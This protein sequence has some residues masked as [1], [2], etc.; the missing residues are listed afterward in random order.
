MSAK[1]KKESVAPPTHFVGIGASAGGLEA[2][3]AFFKNMPSRNNLAFVVVQHLS[4]DYKSLMVELLSKKTEMPV[5]R[6]EEGMEV[7]AGNVYLIPPK[8]N[9]TI[10]HGKLLLND[11]EINQGISL[12]ID[13]FLR[14]LAEDQAERTIAIILSGTGSDGTRGVRAIKEFGGLVMVQTE[15]S[16]KFDGMPRSAISTGVADFILPPEEMPAQLLAYVAHPYVSGEKHTDP[17]LK[18]ADGLTRLFA[19]LRDKTKVDFTYYKPSTI[20]RR[21]ERRMSVNQIGDFEEYVRYLKNYPGEVI[22]LYRDLLI[23]VTNFFRDPEAM[24]ELEERW[25]PELFLRVK[26]REIRFW[27]AGCSTGEE[28]YTIAILAKEVMEKLGISRDVKIFATD[29]DRNAIITAGTGIYPESIIGDLSHKVA[30]KYFYHKA[31]KLQVTRH[32]REMV[33]FAQH[34]LVKDPPFT[35]IDLVSCR[36]LLIYLQPVLQRKAFEMF[37][38]SLNEQGVL[39]LGTSETIGDMADCFES[40]H[41]KHKIYQSKGKS[42]PLHRDVA[43]TAR[44]GSYPAQ[45]YTYGGRDRRRGDTE[46]NRIIKDYLEVASRHYLPLSVIVNERMEVIHFIGNT[47]GYFSLPSGPTDFTITKLAPKDLAIPLATGI[48]KVFRTGEEIVYTNARLQRKNEGVT[49]RIR[50][51]PFPESKGQEPLVTVFLEEIKRSA[52]DQVP[53]VAYDLGEEA[54]NRIKDLEQELQFARE[55]LQA[56]IEELETSNEELQATNEELLASN[57]E[58]Q[59]TNEELQSTNEELYTVN[60][61]HQ[62]KIIELTELNNDVDNLL[63]SSRIGTLMLDE[64]LELRKFS[65]EIA[66]IFHIMEKDIGRPLNHLAHRLVD[67]DPFAAVQKV[68]SSNR[69]LEQEV[70]AGNNQWYLIRILPYTIGPKIYSGVV[71][72]FVDITETRVTQRHLADSRQNTQDIS[73]FIPSGLFIYAENNKGELTLESTNPEAER[74]TGIRATEWV[75]KTFDEIWPDAGRLGLS[76]QFSEVIKTGETCYLE[77]FH[78]QSEHFSG[79][80]RIRAFLLAD[81]RLAVSFEDVTERVKAR[82]ALL[83]SQQFVLAVMNSLASHVCVID[84]EGTIISVNEAW[85]KFAAANPPIRGNIDEGAN[86]LTIC[87]QADGA[88]AE[89]AHAFAAGIRGVLQGTIDQFSLEYP[90][91]S[92]EEQRW[93]L[94]RVSRL[95]GY[96][97]IHAVVVHENTTER[98]RM[99]QERENRDREYR[100]LFE[101]M[102]QG[103]VYQDREGRIIS[104]NPAAERILGLTGDQLRNVTSMD[105]RWRAVDEKG[106]ILPGEQHPAMVAIRTGEPVFGFVMGVQSPK[107][108]TPRWILVNAMPQFQQGEVVPYQVHTTFEDITERCRLFGAPAGPGYI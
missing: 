72:T 49:I 67:F 71:L 48:Q 32:L 90:C 54:Q 63:T 30:T 86:Y 87:D 21:I 36:N 10:F 98:E 61:E 19:E 50:I 101:T 65:P 108:D 4:P 55:N 85:R 26:N 68:Q 58:L 106:V 17:L 18:D 97:K 44:D 22:A 73:Q 94:G 83:E 107:F 103:V 3:E 5:H 46:G 82:K 60:A 35:N 75:G 14:S 13:I 53:V 81:K 100:N 8:K 41:Q 57:E 15:E 42:Q 24:A 47:E 12:P 105:P 25:L 76:T 23:G 38:F 34:N 40:L 74:I 59:S 104:A 92:N 93:F 66:N 91:H 31:D 43:V 56:T 37:N 11:K 1:K 89:T 78:Y 70:C 102:A 99:R 96:E 52:T 9:L 84:E 20:T 33:V 6:A 45:P 2:I 39:F 77:A 51:L 64:D 7:L 88:D 62:N 28:A 69:P 27:V 95:T 79:V 80:F 29:I 16:A